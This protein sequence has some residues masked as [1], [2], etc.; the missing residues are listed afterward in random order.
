MQD[1][2]QLLPIALKRSEYLMVMVSSQ[3]HFVNAELTEFE[4]A[5]PPIRDDRN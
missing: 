1:M 2:M 4:L 5:V 3:S